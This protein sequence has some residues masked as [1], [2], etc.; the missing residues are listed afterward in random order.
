MLRVVCL[1]FIFTRFG[2]ESSFGRDGQPKRVKCLRNYYFDVYQ[3]AAR[4]QMK[5]MLFW[6]HLHDHQLP[7]RHCNEASTPTIR[8]VSNKKCMREKAQPSHTRASHTKI[9]IR[10]GIKKSCWLKC[11]FLALQTNWPQ[12]DFKLYNRINVLLRFSVIC[13]RRQLSFPPL[14]SHCVCVWL[15]VMILIRHQI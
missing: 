4:R 11:A 1:S 13:L 6:C 8:N 12:I 2:L 15:A 7:K 9:R 14:Y 5:M 3:F 10:C